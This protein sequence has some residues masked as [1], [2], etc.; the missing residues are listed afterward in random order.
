MIWIF[1]PDIRYWQLITFEI[2]TVTNSCLSFK[3]FCYFLILQQS[4][5]PTRSYDSKRNFYVLNDCSNSSFLKGI[6]WKGFLRTVCI[7]YFL[8]HTVAS[9][10]GQIWRFVNLSKFKFWA[11]SGKDHQEKSRL[12][13]QKLAT[14]AI[15][16]CSNLVI[17]YQIF[18]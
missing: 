11:D 2:E 15:T 3:T 6:H 12:L 16:I 5:M 7:L 14:L 13:E 1:V 17:V 4:K 18:I 8:W 10:R 9:I